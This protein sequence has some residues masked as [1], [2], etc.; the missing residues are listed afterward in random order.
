MKVCASCK[1]SK[2]KSEFS[3]RSG[4]PGELHSYCKPCVKTKN[5]VYNSA[6]SPT[7]R[8]S[9]RLKTC[10]GIT[11]EQFNEMLVAQDGHCAICPQTD[12]LV[13][14]HKHDAT[15]KVRAILC[16]N[17]NTALGMLV[18]SPEL[19]E[20]AATYLRKHK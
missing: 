7:L 4:R 20:S 14:D 9:Y 5:I 16:R 12:D 3:N 11:L 8:K 15:K 1:Q 10:Y 17:C 2:E 18:D 19:C 6:V 13:V